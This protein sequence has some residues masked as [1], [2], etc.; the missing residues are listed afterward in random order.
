MPKKLCAKVLLTSLALLLSSCAG[1]QVPDKPVCVELDPTRAN[2]VTLITGTNFDID[3]KNRF[4][5]KTYWELRPFMILVPASTWVEVKKFI[6]TICK[7]TNQCQK[8]VKNWE[9]SVNTID[10]N[11]NKKAAKP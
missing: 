2:C 6:V 1:V 5:D 11:L 7:K 8:E 9:R 4:E 10:A 3:E